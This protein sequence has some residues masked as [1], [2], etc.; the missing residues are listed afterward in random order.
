[1]YYKP[2]VALERGT[3]EN[4]N[5]LVRQYIPKN[6]ELKSVT[7]DELE[8]IMT[9]LNHRP[10]K[11]LDFMSPFEIFFEHSIALVS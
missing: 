2:Y 5:E 3:N 7:N 10:R 11:C 6:R 8:M 4:M 9:K 1:M